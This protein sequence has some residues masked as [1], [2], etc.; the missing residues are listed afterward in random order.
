MKAMKVMR[1]AALCGLLFCLTTGSNTATA[2]NAVKDN[3][4]LLNLSLIHI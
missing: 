3:T 2:N 1:N 4:A